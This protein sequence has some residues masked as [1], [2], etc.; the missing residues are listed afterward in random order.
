MKHRG[1]NKADPLVVVRIEGP[2]RMGQ[3]IDRALH[4][5]DPEAVLWIDIDRDRSLVER[6]FTEPQAAARARDRLLTFIAARAPGLSRRA[7]I[8]SL[9]PRQWTEAWKKYF[10]ARR[11]TPRLVVRPPWEKI[12]KRPNDCVITIDPGMSFGTGLHPTTRS[13]LLLLERWIKTIDTVSS[14]SFLDIGCGSG[15]LAIAAAQKGFRRVEAFDYDPQSITDAQENA[16]RNRVH[17][18]IDFRLCDITRQALRRKCDVVVANLL[19]PLL[20]EQAERIGRSVARQPHAALIVSGILVRQYPRVKKCFS[21]LGFTETASR[22]SGQWHSGWFTP[23]TK[24][25]AAS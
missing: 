22:I 3:R 7:T 1:H 6:Y 24:R 15:I 21:A 11:I 4:R 9:H 25:H 16:R 17:D 13:C 5:F 14:H 10:H 23:L 19:A 20:I 18:R 8:S 12:R 2:R